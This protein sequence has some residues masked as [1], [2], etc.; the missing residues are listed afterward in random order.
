MRLRKGIESAGISIVSNMPVVRKLAS[1]YLL[2]MQDLLSLEAQLVSAAVR[3]SKSVNIWR[4][5]CPW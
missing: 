4:L 1:I 5:D 2:V 3:Q